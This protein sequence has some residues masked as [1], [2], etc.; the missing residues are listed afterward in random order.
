MKFKVLFIKRKYIYYLVLASIVLVF[1]VI[2]H[3]LKNKETSPTFVVNLNSKAYKADLTGDGKE[4]ILYISTNKN[5]Y[6]LEVDTQ[7]DNL[8]LEP[9]KNIKTLGIYYPYWTMKIKLL[10]ISRDNVPEIFIQTSEKNK[11]LQHI[12]IYNYGKFEN[13]FSSHNNVLGF[14]D[15][16][17]NKTPKFISGNISKGNFIFHNYILLQNKLEQF[18]HISNDT[19][20]GKDTILYLINFIT[21]VTKDS[22]IP[23]QQIFS[24]KINDTSLALIYALINADNTYVFQDAQFM[25][26]KSTKDGEPSQIQWILNFRGISNSNREVIKNYTIQVTLKAFNN[27]KERYYFKIDSLNQLN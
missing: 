23:D 3:S 27:S 13:I 26:I 8:F 14:I 17:N 10:D 18:N 5:K 16:S 1:F 6:Y 20:L 25:D 19:F 21:T 7:K 9:N 12:F 24:P 22:K 2:F 11:P 15:C 4:D